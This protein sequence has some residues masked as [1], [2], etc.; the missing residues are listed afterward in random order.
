MK[1]KQSISS[2]VQCI[3]ADAL[4][5]SLDK[6]SLQTSQEEIS[7]WDSMAY[8]TIISIIE[9]EFSVLVS[10]ENINNFGSIEQIIEQIKKCQ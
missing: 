1:N 8:L 9:D 3:V 6:V 5:L 2:R 4:N 7:E 10:E